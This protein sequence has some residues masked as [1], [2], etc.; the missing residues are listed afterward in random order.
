MRFS[1]LFPQIVIASVSITIDFDDSASKRE[2]S[3]L[4]F[5]SDAA[6]ED[7]SS[8]FYAVALVVCTCSLMAV[9]FFSSF[10]SP[11]QAAWASTASLIDLC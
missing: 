1:S 3:S 5:D 4:S 10:S 7:G 8:L 11:L 2:S 9:F 6:R